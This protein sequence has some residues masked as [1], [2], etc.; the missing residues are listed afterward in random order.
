MT[1]PIVTTR[2]ASIFNPLKATPVT[3]I[4]VGATGSRVFA[5]LVELGCSLIQVIDFDKVE[6]HNL[7]NQI[8]RESDIGWLKTEACR[9]WYTHKI[10]SSPPDAMKF[11]DAKLPDNNI[12]VCGVVFLLVDTMAARRQIFDACLRD[13]LNVHRVIETRMASSYGDMIAFDPL[14]KPQ[15][16][17]WINTLVDDAD[18]EV[19]ACGTSISVSP[20]ASLIANLAVWEYVRFCNLYNN[21]MDIV[22]KRQRVFLDPELITSEVSL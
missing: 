6:S 17:A 19:S 15:C 18:A 2:H 21:D 10:G 16:D 7:A 12:T 4:G 8:Y 22:S 13:N 5:S 11:I 20:T 9:N 3:I 14:V 1:N